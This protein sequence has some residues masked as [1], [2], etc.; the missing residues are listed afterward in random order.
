VLADAGVGWKDLGFFSVAGQ[1]L[2]VRF[3]NDANGPV[4]AGAVV[5]PKK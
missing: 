2:T 3:S 4:I 1:A 5:V